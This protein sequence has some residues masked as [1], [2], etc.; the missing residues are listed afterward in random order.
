M[1]WGIILR[2]VDDHKA[3]LRG[4]L[5]TAQNPLQIQE[6]NLILIGKLPRADGFQRVPDD[7][8]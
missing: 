8:G 6:R 5:Q 2:L 7:A 1:Q 3:N 4:L